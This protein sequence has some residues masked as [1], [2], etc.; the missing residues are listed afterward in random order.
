MTWVKLEDT[1][2]THPKAAGLSPTAATI[3]LRAICYS[4]AHL[5]DGKVPVA[6]IA[7][8][9]YA[10]WRHSLDT[11]STC[12]LVTMSRECIE[13][14]DYLDY[15]RSSE[16]ARKLKEKRALAGSKGG[17]AKAAKAKQTSSKVLDGGLAEE[18]RREPSPTPSADSTLSATNSAASGGEEELLTATFELMARQ[19]LERAKADGAIIR[20]RT[21][22]LKATAINRRA[23]H[24]TA[25]RH[26]ATTTLGRYYPAHVELAELLDP[27]C[28]PEDG[29]A[30]RARAEW[31]QHQAELAAERAARPPRSTNG[32]DLARAALL[33]HD[34][35]AA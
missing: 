23:E 20:N 12:S 18:K 19:D 25:A 1:F 17:T 32:A 33:T 35:G 27:A 15:Q 8:W 28:G 30:H 34:Q 24:E 14:H 16:E 9:G 13:I 26:H 5:T 2:F 29:G 4:S 31:E 22:W 7:S 21:A 6:V 10:R 3:Y 11:L